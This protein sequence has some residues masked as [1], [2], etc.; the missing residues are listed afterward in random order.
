MSFIAN[1]PETGA[2]R[3]VIIGAGFAGLKLARDLVKAPYQVVL[4]DKYNYHQFQPLMYQVATASLESSSISFPLRKI[5]QDADNILIRNTEITYINV[6]SKQLTTADMGYINYDILVLA[7]G[8]DTNFFGNEEI[9]RFALPMKSVSEAIAMRNRILT[10]YEKAIS[11]RDY[12]DRQ[13]LL[14]IV[15]A[16]GGPTGVE[17]AG[18]LAEMKSYIMP[19]D[20]K[21][22]DSS[23]IDIYLVDG[24]SRLLGTMSESAG[25]AAEQYLEKMGVKVIKNALIK[26]YDGEVVTF[27]D[28]T[29]IISDKLIWAAGV[30]VHPISGIPDSAYGRGWRLLV[31]EYNQSDHFPDIYAIGDC[32]I[33]ITERFPAGHPQVA[34][35]AIQQ[36]GNLAKNLRAMKENRKL[37]PFKYK[38]LG[39]MATVGRKRA[40]VDLPKFK[41]KGFFAWL[42]WLFVHLMAIL[43]TKNKIFIF[44]NWAWS[45]ITRD[46]SLRLIMRPHP[47]KGEKAEMRKIY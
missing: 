39:S 27:S 22:I 40:V 29:T 44:L 45:Y 11:I 12:N 47:P 46:Q 10:D 33:M 9:S 26:K 3:V 7:Y 8:T 24:G 18:A 1:L 17:I 25:Q 6:E 16:G 21:E 37:K 38:D 31:N 4:I 35:T 34:Q 5:F 32:S 42:T 2:P 13:R 41:F 20:Y 43:G 19:K 15:I 36:A 23:E 14:D 28:G 30:T